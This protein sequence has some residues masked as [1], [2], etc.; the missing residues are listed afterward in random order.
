MLKDSGANVH[1][2]GLLKSCSAFTMHSA[3]LGNKF[4]FKKLQNSRKVLAEDP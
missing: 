4:G 2:Q 3:F 1:E